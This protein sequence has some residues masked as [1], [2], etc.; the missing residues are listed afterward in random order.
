LRSWDAI[1]AQCFLFVSKARIHGENPANNDC[2]RSVI[3][4][5]RG[6][7]QRDEALRR[8]T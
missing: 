8:M 3:G 2:V 1:I 4:M 5:P 6:V 7:A